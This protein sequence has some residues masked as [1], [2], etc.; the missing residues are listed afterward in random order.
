MQEWENEYNLPLIGI[1]Q[2]ITVIG[3]A[4]FSF[5]SLIREGKMTLRRDP[6]FE[7]AVNNVQLM[8]GQNG[9]RRPT[10]EKST[11]IIDPC[12]AGIQATAIAID[13]GAMDPPAYRTEADIVI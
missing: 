6:V 4:T 9:D 12:I 2:T 11:G 5:E 7:Y 10:K 8:V 1:P 13:K 3:P